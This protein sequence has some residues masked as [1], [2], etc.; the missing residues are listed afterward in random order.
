M[1]WGRSGG[2]KKEGRKME[3]REKE[4]NC[5]TQ[6]SNREI[7]KLNPNNQM[8][9]VNKGHIQNKNILEAHRERSLKDL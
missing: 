1:Y 8:I 5:L 9:V 7:F 6:K 4:I 2:G 3:I